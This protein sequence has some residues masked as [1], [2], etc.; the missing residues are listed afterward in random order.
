M[1]AV[2]DVSGIMQILL[3]MPKS[4]SFSSIL[5]EATLVLAPDLYVSELTNVLWK[6]YSAKKLSKEECLAYIKDGIDFIDDFVSTKDIWNSA[7]LAGINNE[8]S[9][10]DMMYMI[11]AKNYNAVLITNDKDLSVICEKNDVKVVF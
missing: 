2:V 7:F 1:I 5:Q 8:H 10:Y 3:Q 11:S 9:I 6:Y 4:E